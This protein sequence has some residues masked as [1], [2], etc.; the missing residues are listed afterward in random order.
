MTAE[1]RMP[2]AW[3]AI[4]RADQA[5]LRSY[6]D[7]FR[8]MK[9]PT[10]EAMPSE[11]RNLAK[12]SSTL[13]TGANYAEV[14]REALKLVEIIT[15]AA[16]I[17]QDPGNLRLHTVVAVYADGETKK[18]RPVV[19]GSWFGKRPM[20]LLDEGQV[21]ETFEKAVVLFALR[22]N[23]IYPQVPLRL[24]I[25]LVSRAHA[26][27][28]LKKSKNLERSERIPL[29]GDTIDYRLRAIPEGNSFS[30]SADS[31]R[32]RVPLGRGRATPRF[33]LRHAHRVD[34]A[35]DIAVP[36]SPTP[37]CGSLVSGRPRKEP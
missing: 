34:R 2:Q 29:D 14:Q 16:K 37:S 35:R 36:A 19:T 24:P 25:F 8:A 5:S 22:C 1:A 10:L 33:S 21:H 15:G 9:D 7:H 3:Y 23:N 13:F 26:R 32:K 4:V 30:K 6:L 17:K 11:G 12:L 28:R 20:I 31:R 18:F 27:V